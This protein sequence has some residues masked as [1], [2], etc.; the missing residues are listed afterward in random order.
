MVNH[1][2][3]HVFTLTV[4]LQSTFYMCEKYLDVII[5]KLSL[6]NFIIGMGVRERHEHNTTS[7]QIY[8]GKGHSLI[9]A[10]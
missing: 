6:Q 8:D 9:V 3:F 5:I 2:T 1:C 4:D 10:T 7:F